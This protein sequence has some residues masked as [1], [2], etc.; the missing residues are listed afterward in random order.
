MDTRSI[1]IIVLTSLLVISGGII[2]FQWY[3]QTATTVDIPVPD[4]LLPTIP[5]PV[6]GDES[7]PTWVDVR[8]YFP[9]TDYAEL[10]ER[11][12]QIPPPQLLEER[13]QRVLEE[14][15][16]GPSDHDLASPVPA[17]TEVRSLFWLE[18]DNR[19]LVSFSETILNDFRGHAQAEWATIYSIVNTIA[20]QS[21]AIRE[22]QILVE[23]MPVDSSHTLWDWSY[24]FQP[25]PILFVRRDL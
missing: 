18:S 3:T 23:G 12:I 19:V 24:P 13:I 9:T 11:T 20:A 21:A 17:G 15:I 14:L 5:T 7:E 22:V 2:A 6:M 4:N 1:L 8:I 25:E 10:V 16:R